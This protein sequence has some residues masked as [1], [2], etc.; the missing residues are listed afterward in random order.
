MSCKIIDTK[1]HSY[2]KIKTYITIGLNL[3]K[4]V[5][6]YQKNDYESEREK[7]IDGKTG[8]HTWT[9]TFESVELSRDKQNI[10]LSNLCCRQESLC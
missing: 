7:D 1:Y 3:I 4:N 9:H 2:H 8:Q 10:N 5:I 6:R